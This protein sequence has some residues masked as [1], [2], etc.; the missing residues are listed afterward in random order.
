MK[1]FTRYILL[2]AA[3]AMCAVA[4]AQNG[5]WREMHKVESKE[6][7]YGIAR[8]YGLTVDELVKANPEMG[9]PGYQLKKGD[10]IFIPYSANQGEATAQARTAAKAAVPAGALRV[11]VVLPLH[12]NDGDGRRMLE[13]YRG[14]LMACEDL[15]KEGRSVAVSAWNVPI[16]ADIY[17]TLVKDDMAK[18]DIV[19]G[20][21]YSKQVKPLSFF[22][23]DNGIK[24][25]IPFSITGD[26]VDDNPNIFQVYQSAEDF[27]GM[28]AAQFA[29]RFK[30]YN[31]VVID[32][33]DRTSD[34][35]VFTFTLRKRLE[36]KGIPCNVT[37]L[38]SSSGMFARAF[39][40]SKPNIVVLNTGRS[41]E[42]NTV[43]DM[44]D[45]LTGEHPELKVS[46]FGY[47]EWLLYA[48]YN[49]GKFCKYD[50]YVPT[51]F[52]YNTYS[53]KVK[54]F[55][56]RYRAAFKSDMM[57]YQ[58]RFALTGYDHGMFFIGG[59]LRQGKKFDGSEENTAALQTRL[60]F[61]KTGAGG[62][63]RNVS[64][65]FVHYNRDNSISIIN[66]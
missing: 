62:G 29:Y 12:N 20:P 18:C 35:G 66:F 57:D 7:L 19:F 53:T 9:V 43:I 64:L 49:M 59:M 42:L 39:S 25:V 56:A 1:H 2:F 63:Y 46:L 14:L 47:T 37:N 52:Y 48:K 3:V 41:P 4:T 30:D 10:Y 36:E 60:R 27:Y 51:N 58:P 28:V 34:K 54:N 40:V 26:D 55:E 50:T 11:G 33:N 22:S 44:L 6:T 21:L 61:K 17:R 38:K 13:Y 5:K 32:C 45:A 65:Q 23:R 31:V 24:L 15:K 16:D 8:E